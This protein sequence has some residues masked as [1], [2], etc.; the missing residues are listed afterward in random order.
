M[1]KTVSMLVVGFG[2]ALAV[3]VACGVS[4]QDFACQTWCGTDVSDFTFITLQA[5][6]TQGA[7]DGCFTELGGTCTNGQLR[8][9]SCTNNEGCGADLLCPNGYCCPTSAPYL[10]ASL[11]PG[12][13]AT[14]QAAEATAGCTGIVFACGV[15][16]G[17]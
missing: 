3:L 13:Y 15:G 5:D 10:C 8:K 14:Q 2:G 16:D 11:P 9:C 1:T 12:C 7:Q 4:S 6:T 17:G